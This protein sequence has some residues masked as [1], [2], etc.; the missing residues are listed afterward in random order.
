MKVL[1]K[2]MKD[3]RGDD[4][5]KDWQLFLR[6]LDLYKSSVDGDFGKG[7]HSATVKFQKKYG[8][9]ADGVVGNRTYAKAFELDF[10][11]LE[12]DG[13]DKYSA[14]WPPKPNFAQLT[15]AKRK[16][17]FGAFD[18]SPAPTRGNPEG[19]KIHG[20]W[21]KENITRVYIPQL[22]GVY[23]APKSGKIYWHK[24]G[25][26]Q[27]VG[28]FQ[29]WEDAGLMDRV[30]SWA[31]SWVPRYI[32]GSRTSLSNHSWA[33]AFDINVPWNGLKRLP[34]LVGKKGSVRELVPLANEYGFYWGGHW[35]YGGR[36]RYD[37][38]HFELAMV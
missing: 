22:V 33:T 3:K 15:P 8:L 37:G 1:R 30:E 10:C 28:L 2:G 24:K 13:D 14:N 21:V 34:A 16:R 4:D 6:G 20:N 36:G 19:I 12:D 5:V 25:E 35:G 32:R 27:I 11:P 38:M 23:G 29:A 31:G 7:T 9:S 26:E 18:F 17:I